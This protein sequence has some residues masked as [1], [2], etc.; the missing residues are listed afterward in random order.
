[1][2]YFSRNGGLSPRNR[3]TDF[4]A[5]I[6]NARAWDLIDNTLENPKEMRVA[7]DE[8]DCGAR[9]LD[10]GVNVH[11]SLA[12]GLLLTRVCTAGLADVALHPGS[13]NG[14]T[15]PQVQITTD[16]PVS[17]CL[18][19]QYAGWEIK[20]GDFFAMGSGP[21]RA[22]AGR[23]ALFE[24]LGYQENFYCSV[25]VLE[26]DKL[27]G[28]DV[29]C[30]IAR[31]ARVEPRNLILLA[32]STSSIAGSLQINARSVETALHKLHELGFD[33][34][35]IIS[36]HGT[37][38]LSPA[39]A[40]FLTAIGRTNDAILYGGRVTLY[41]TGDDASIEQIGPQVPSS[42][43]KGYGQTFKQVFKEA[44]HDFYKIDPLLFSPA[45]I[46]FQNVDTGRVHAFGQTDEQLLAESF[47]LAG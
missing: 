28:S 42:A 34:H 19:S 11:G 21:M 26:T 2:S 15:W 46:V 22:I 20:T 25:G 1:M 37:A 24:Q 8:M 29:V 6:L 40:D 12:A 43:A 32:A 39:A 23:E 47:G 18:Y 9:L 3:N 41:V 38:P 27:P 36:A 13:I 5:I 33:V 10:F 14:I 44:G 16:F 30:D 17:A 31:K 45:Q 4:M 7:V 35:R